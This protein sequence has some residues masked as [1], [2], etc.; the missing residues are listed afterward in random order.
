MLNTK[1]L[2]VQT[3]K[4]A[5]MHF[6][7]VWIAIV[8][9]LIF[10]SAFAAVV[11]VPDVEKLTEQSTLIV[12]GELTSTQRDIRATTVDFSGRRINVRV[13]RGTFRI[14]QVLKGDHQPS[15]VTVEFAVP[16]TSLG[17]S[18]PPEHAYGLFFFKDTGGTLELTDVYHAWISVP[19]GISV[20]AGTPLEGVVEV[21]GEVISIP[22]SS[23][24]MKQIALWYLEFAKSDASTRALRGVITNADP[25]VGV[26]AARALMLRGD[27]SGLEV[28]KRAFLPGPQSLPS[29]LEET[30]SNAIG[31]GI[32]DPKLIP[33]L[34]EL[35]SSSSRYMRRGV[36]MALMRMGSLDALN[37][38][39]RALADSDFEVRYYGVLG[40]ART[41][42]DARGM[43]PHM[44]EFKADEIKYLSYWRERVN[45]QKL[46]T[47]PRNQE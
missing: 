15:P 40:L 29:L 6:R 11:P 22:D 24:D 1:M 43:T 18:V 25:I 21:L 35:L 36:A 12:V 39:G 5:F 37:G 44:E 34:E 46:P 19:R 20:T 8:L 41:T 32:R 13:Q 2:L 33:D 28:I 47:S 10:S 9:G 17:W 4:G 31:I 45:A 14:D 3:R 26:N 7:P 27:V 16:D 30:V 42:G 23:R 38:L